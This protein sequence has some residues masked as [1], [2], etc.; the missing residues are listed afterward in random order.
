[1]SRPSSTAADDDSRTSSTRSSIPGSARVQPARERLHIAVARFGVFGFRGLGI[2]TYANYNS[3]SEHLFYM[4]TNF[5]ETTEKPRKRCNDQQIGGLGGPGPRGGE[6][7]CHG[8]DRWVRH[9][10]H[11]GR[12]Y[13]WP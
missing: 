12:A 13:R 5:K 3:L 11:S 9:G 7:W 6:G 4:R 2:H 8:V 1:M 10:R